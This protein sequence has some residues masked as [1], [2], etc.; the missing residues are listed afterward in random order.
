MRRSKDDMQQHDQE[1]H[2]ENRLDGLGAMALLERN[3]HLDNGQRVRTDDHDRAISQLHQVAK[4]ILRAGYPLFSIEH[5]PRRGSWVRRSPLGAR[6]LAV[7]RTD[8]D[9]IQMD[10]P[11][12][13]FSPVMMVFMKFRHLIPFNPASYFDLLMPRHAAEQIFEVAVRALGLLQRM[14][15][16]PYLR[17]LHNNFRRKAID[18]FN[19]LIDSI[20]ALSQRRVSV[21][22][23]RFD[24][25]YRRAGSLPVKFGDQPDVQILD[26]LMSLRERFHRSLDRRFGGELLGYAWVLEFGRERGFHFHYLVFLKH[27]VPGDD[28]SL[29]E[30]LEAKWKELTDGR[31]ELDNVNSRRRGFRYPAVGRIRLDDPQV[32]TGLQYLVSYM[33]LAPLFVKLEIQE[34]YDTFAKGRFSAFSDKS[35]RLKA[36]TSRSRIKISVDEAIASRLTFI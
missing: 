12:H 28:V 25:Y 15:R 34:R 32:V 22:A 31:G 8:F 18:N 7:F 29:V 11:L 27:G 14:L 36:Q 2:E 3:Y 6:L 1:Q 19:G 35:G 20:D 13:K 10:Y 23:L 26:E 24:L 4:E 30:S 5:D 9:R 16:R 17:R 33:T 21:T